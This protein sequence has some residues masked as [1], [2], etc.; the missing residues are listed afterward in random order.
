V[1]GSIGTAF[2]APSFADLYYPGYANPTLQPE[3]S[4]GGEL[5]VA[6]AEHGRSASATWFSNRIEDLIAFDWT[7]TKPTC[8]SGCPVNVKRA[9]TEGLELAANTPLGG[10]FDIAA[11]ATLQ[12]A[13]DANTNRRLSRRAESYGSLSLNWRTGAWRVGSEL[14]ASG[15][16]FDSVNES[17]SSRL[18]GYGYVN[19]LADYRVS[20]Q[21]SLFGRWNNVFDKDY[22]LLKGYDTPGSNVF[23][24][25]RYQSK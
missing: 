1:S 3:S 8:P 23:V 5:A 18:P 24:G 7:V 9:K 15:D 4:V 10:G 19:L 6:Y 11:R 13:V 16:R 22:D 20:K 12:Q 2:R 17:P 25:V 21:W 14:F